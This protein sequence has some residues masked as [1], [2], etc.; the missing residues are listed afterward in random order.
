MN[1]DLWV[2]ANFLH[3]WK[4][5]PL[6]ADSCDRSCVIFAIK[7]FIAKVLEM[8]QR[9]EVRLI[10]CSHTSAVLLCSKPICISLLVRLVFTL[11]CYKAGQSAHP[12]GLSALSLCPDVTASCADRA[13]HCGTATT[14]SRRLEPSNTLQDARL[15]YSLRANAR[16]QRSDVPGCS[17]SRRCSSSWED[18]CFVEPVSQLLLLSTTANATEYSDSVLF[19]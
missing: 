6:K 4:P 13:L 15:H 14:M 19:F 2:S 9:M 1:L 8:L 7:I 16:W 5:V 17:S 3:F 18:S 11:H 12:F 10:G